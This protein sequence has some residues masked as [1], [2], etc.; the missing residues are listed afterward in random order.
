MA[1]KKR[2]KEELIKSSDHLHYEVWMFQSLANAMASN[3]LGTGPINNS[4]LEAFI[5]HTRNLIHFLYAEKPKND[6]VVACDFI[7]KWEELCPE[8]SE[9]LQKA[10][11]RANKEVSHL[12]YDRQKVTPE[13]KPWE[14][15]RVVHE[16]MEIFKLFLDNVPK[17]LLGNRWGNLQ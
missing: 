8:K 5:V 7:T 15:I 3:I 16:V 17:E 1:R 2:T 11:R 6:H 14:F 13:D 10:E 9:F 12:S 4:A